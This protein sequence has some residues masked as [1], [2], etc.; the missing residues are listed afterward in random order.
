MNHAIICW[1]VA[2]FMGGCFECR[3]ESIKRG[4]HEH[5]MAWGK[6]A[7]TRFIFRVVDTDGVPVENANVQ[8]SFGENWGGWNKGLTDSNGIFAVE[9]VSAGEM[10]Y[11]VRKQNYYDTDGGYKWCGAGEII[12]EDG[13]WL[14]WG[15]TNTI[16]LKKIKNP[17]A[18]FAARGSYVVPTNGCP[19]GF[20]LIVGDWVS[21][22]GKGTQDDL[23]V[24]LEEKVSD[25]YTWHKKLMITFGKSTLD[26]VCIQPKDNYSFFKS[27]YEAPLN[28]YS[29]AEVW[30][31]DRVKESVLIDTGSSKEDCLIF[32][33]RTETNNS[34]KVVSAYYG[35]IYGPVEY[36]RIGGGKTWLKINYYLNPTPNDRNLEFDPNKNL[37]GGRDR[38]AP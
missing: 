27:S 14:P 7:Q 6:G 38:F 26:G 35:K 5:V 25:A 28:G 23:V 15:V 13:R 3:S 20:D 24:Y 36:G 32:R 17:V 10:I 30:E 22:Y 8:A 16:I 34:G 31:F 19:I 37:F 18:L 29:K 1:G 33:I 2:I 12:I 21:P 9:R 11:N 4:S